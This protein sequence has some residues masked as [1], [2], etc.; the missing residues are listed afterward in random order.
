MFAARQRCAPLDYPRRATVVLSRS[1]EMLEHA[2]QNTGELPE[3]R[4]GF[5]VRSTGV[6]GGNVGLDPAVP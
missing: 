3:R 4:G 2:A 6:G 5:I 1:Q